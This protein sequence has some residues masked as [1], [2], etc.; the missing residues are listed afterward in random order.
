MMLV[1][2][3]TRGAPRTVWC[4]PA[5]QTVEQREA[6][7][8]AD[9]VG[10]LDG[11]LLDRLTG[12]QGAGTNAARAKLLGVNKTSLWRWRTGRFRPN[13]DVAQRVADQLGTTV[14]QL[15]PRRAA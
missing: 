15:F 8:P 2:W 3:C 13:L 9:G 12:L 6:S 11:A 4:M 10:L 14:D 7:A 5:P 1:H